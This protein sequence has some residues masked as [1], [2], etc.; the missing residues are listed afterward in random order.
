M[1]SAKASL[2]ANIN[3][4]AIDNLDKEPVLSDQRDKLREIYEQLN[5]A[6]EEYG[7]ARQQYGKAFRQCLEMHRNACCFLSLE[8]QISDTNPE[9]TWVLLQT[10]ASELERATEVRVCR[11]L[12]EGLERIP[13]EISLR[14]T[15]CSEYEPI[16]RLIFE[17]II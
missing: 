15:F 8:E 7:A 2:K 4:L 1:E 6:R 14:N 3:R 16:G 9:I 10:A 17:E 12:I 5:K 11:C 13:V